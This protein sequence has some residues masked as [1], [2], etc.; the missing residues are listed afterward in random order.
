MVQ[1][2]RF[3]VRVH[4]RGVRLTWLGWEEGQPVGRREGLR[5][6][7]VGSKVGAV[8]GV[9]GLHE[10]AAVSIMV[11]LLEMQGLVGCGVSSGRLVL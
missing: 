9:C 3:G 4:P 6:G 11:E 5:L 7:V 10:G 8:V 1:P 2:R